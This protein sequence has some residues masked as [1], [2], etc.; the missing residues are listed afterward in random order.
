MVSLAP[1][2]RGNVKCITQR[3][4]ELLGVGERLWDDKLPGF[5]VRCQGRSKTFGLQAR[6]RGKQRW[7]TIGKWGVLTPEEAR[8]L[9]PGC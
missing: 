3:Q 8:Q 1:T 5:C 9:G 7:L 6:I 4:V 2:T